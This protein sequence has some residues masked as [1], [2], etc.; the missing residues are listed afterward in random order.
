MRVTQHII[1][2]GY[3]N[4]LMRKQEELYALHRQ[5]SSGK[6][7]NVPSDDPV[8]TNDIL[9]AKSLISTLDQYERNIDSAVSYLNVTEKTLDTFTNTLTNIRELGITAQSGTADAGTR[10]RI[11]T[12]V[13][14]LYDELISLG[15]TSFE[16]KY[17]F[18]GYKTSTAA[19]DSAGTFLGDANKKSYRIGEGI[20]MT[21]GYNGGEVFKGTAGGVDV[22]QAVSDLMTALNADDSAGIETAMGTLESAF[23]QI[24][25]TTASLGARITRLNATQSDLVN[26]RLNMRVTLSNIE[27]ADIT[28]VISRLKLSQVAL[29]AAMTSAGR[30]FSLN[31]FNYI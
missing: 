9:D 31:I 27:D 3:V 5:I 12:V 1:Y 25:D 26:T 24:T 29:E 14:G 10:A 30:V 16:N 15:N 22:F 21:V 18:S 8:R 11:A 28:E 13:K 4:D 2:N 19:F 23:T 20:T 17:I 6:K 7:V